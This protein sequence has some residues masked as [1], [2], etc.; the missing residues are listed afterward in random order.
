MKE[1]IDAISQKI[2]E[3]MDTDKYQYRCGLHDAKVIVD[4]RLKFYQSSPTL[5]WQQAVEMAGKELNLKHNNETVGIYSN[6]TICQRAAAL[7]EANRLQ[8]G[9]TNE[10]MKS[11]GL[12]MTTAKKKDY[13]GLERYFGFQLPTT[14]SRIDAWQ[15]I[16]DKTV[17]DYFEEW[18][19]LPV[20]PEVPKQ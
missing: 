14:K 8:I 15:R 9:Y 10:Q 12:F 18:K 19:L 7:M 5:T 17:E 2:K 20:V 13:E 4:T 16:K 1:I 11:F 3:N 6:S